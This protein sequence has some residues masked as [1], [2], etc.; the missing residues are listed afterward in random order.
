MG[1][2][3]TKLLTYF[4]LI[5]VVPT[6]VAFYGFDTFANRRETQKVDT[7][8]R[9]DVRFAVAG[10]AQE[11]GA[12]ERRATPVP[13]TVAIQRLLVNL[14]PR[15]TLVA[16]RNGEIVAGPMLGNE[17]PLAPGLPAEVDVG[18]HEFRGVLSSAL[19]SADGMQFAALARQSELDAAQTSARLRIAAA[20]VAAVLGIGGL[21]FLLGLSISRTLTRLIRATDAIARGEWSERVEVR[22]HDEFARVGDAFNRMATQLEQ[23]VVE[24]EDERRRSREATSRFADVL[25]ATHDVDQLLRVVVETAVEVT[26]AS[27]GVVIGPDTEVART[28]ELKAGGQVLELPLRAARRDFG[29]IVLAGENFDDATREAA[30]SL[31]SHAVVA[32]E[33]AHLHRVVER[34]ARIDE[35]TGIANRR[36][37]E[38]MLRGE[39]ARAE[40]FGGDVCFVFA[41]LDNFKDVND[42]YGHPFGDVVLSVFAEVLGETVRDVDIAGRW[43]GEEFALVLPGTDAEGG[44]AVADRARRALL[45]REVRSPSGDVLR[46]TASFGV[47]AFPA[48]P[49]SEALVAAADDALYLAKRAGRDRVGTPDGLLAR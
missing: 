7:R 23:R 19:A 9:A 37:V 10:Y 24:L 4:A 44:A 46:L 28:G 41:D 35:L 38:E 34:Q 25:A 29:T 15:D 16:V 42:R 45:H 36:A 21:I 47:A 11:I 17:L 2:F 48:C 31:I 22:G 49:D 26:G 12:A 40:R 18:G 39:L 32:L 5:A 6:C 13:I 1:S 3:R 30:V 20:L 27:G 43:G 33:N 14:D 8:L